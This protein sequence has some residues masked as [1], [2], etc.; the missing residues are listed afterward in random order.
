MKKLC[1][2]RVKES[3]KLQMSRRLLSFFPANIYLFKFT[4][5]I[6]NFEHISHLLLLLL[7]LKK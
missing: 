3:K 6:A 7:V 1:A 5:S 2:S 4:F